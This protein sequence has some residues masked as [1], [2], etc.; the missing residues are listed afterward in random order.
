MLL[1]NNLSLAGLQYIPLPPS[2]G[3]STGGDSILQKYYRKST[4]NKNSTY[5]SLKR[6]YTFKTKKFRNGLIEHFYQYEITGLTHYKGVYSF[7]PAFSKPLLENGDAS[8][9]YSENM[10]YMQMDSLGITFSQNENYSSSAYFYIAGNIVYD[11]VDLRSSLSQRATDSYQYSSTQKYFAQSEK[12]VKY[13]NEL[14]MDSGSAKMCPY[15]FSL[16]IGKAGDFYVG[17]YT[18]KDYKNWWGAWY[19]ETTKGSFT[20]ANESVMSF[21]YVTF[22]TGTTGIENYYYA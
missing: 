18:R 12:K 1:S 3:G 13:K 6:Y 17:T 7:F 5:G 14:K 10:E 8:M 16:S 22:K 9:T 21:V 2:G 20:I 19:C 11:G 4:A 15:G